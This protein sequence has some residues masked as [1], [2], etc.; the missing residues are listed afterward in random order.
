MNFEQLPTFFIIGA[1]KAGTTTLYDTIKQYPEVYLPVQKEPS[2]FCD[3]EYYQ[4]GLEWYQMVFFA[5]AEKFKDRGDATPR[6][7]YWAERVVPRLKAIYGDSSPKFIAIFREPASLVYSYYWQ[8]VREGREDFP[9]DEALQLEAERMEKH[10]AFLNYRGRIVYAYSRIALY[11]TQL[12]PY[13]EAFPR[14]HFLFLVTEDLQD[15]QQLTKKIEHFLELKHKSNNQ[16]VRSNVA[17][18]PRNRRLHQW[19][20]QRSGFKDSL[21]KIMPTTFRYKLKLSAI[22]LNLKEFEVPPPD[23]DLVLQLKRHYLP[24]IKQLEKLIDR[25]L[26]NWYSDLENNE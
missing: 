8:N 3:E 7:L 17:S 26:S 1:A 13:M 4:K 6:Y 21:K 20:R 10:Q 25:D 18:L 14:D 5:G 15:Y 19:L 24:E 23:P 16:P 9:F 11:A 2:F 12:K 22:K